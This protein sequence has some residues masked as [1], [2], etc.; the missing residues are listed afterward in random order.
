MEFQEAIKEALAA[1]EGLRKMGFSS[2]DIYVRP[3]AVRERF[4]AIHMFLEVQ[5]IEFNILVDVFD[6]CAAE[7]TDQWKKAA[8]WWNN[9]GTDEQLD[10][11]WKNSTMFRSGA[12]ALAAQLRKRGIMI[13]AFGGRTLH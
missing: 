3:Q 8:H 2:D 9:V 6:G 10:E 12:E 11:V 1:Q 7:F 5:G 4:V 13:P